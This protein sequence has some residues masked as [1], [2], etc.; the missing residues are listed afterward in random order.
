MNEQNVLVDKLNIFQRLNEV[1]KRV[2]YLKRD[3][4]VD[5]YKAVTHDQ[6]TA[7]TRKHL[8]EHG[9]L[10]FPFEISSAV[11]DSGNKSGKG[12]VQLRFEAKYRVD[13]I[14]IDQPTDR[15]SIEL[16]AHANDYGD[17][18]PG[19]AASYATKTAILKML[20]IETGEDDESRYA[21]D[22]PPKL[23]ESLLTAAKVCAEQ[24]LIAYSK[25]WESITNE[26]RAALSATKHHADFKLVASDIDK[27][28][29]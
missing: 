26:E 13:F 28:K 25:F 7:M 21:E 6:V 1:K 18:A 23:S 11:V 4:S 9:V 2:D 22:E 17:K 3:K 14:N 15:V 19:K 27:A 12:T 29:K 5:T 16:T 10:L 20:Q 8:I 24:G